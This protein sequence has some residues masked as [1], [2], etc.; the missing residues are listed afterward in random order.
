MTAL[1]ATTPIIPPRQA[2]RQEYFVSGA[3]SIEA[4]DTAALAA[5]LPRYGN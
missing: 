5:V 1:V 4:G 2:S 3:R